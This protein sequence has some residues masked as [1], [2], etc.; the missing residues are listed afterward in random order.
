[1]YCTDVYVRK[2]DVIN[3]G[4]YAHNSR[5]NAII[6][7]QILPTIQQRTQQNL[8]KI[9]LMTIWL[10]SNDCVRSDS[11]FHVSV[12]DFNVNM[13][14]MISLIRDHSPETRIILITPGPCQVGRIEA[15]LYAALN[16]P[17]PP[18]RSNTQVK[19]YV[20]AVLEIGAKTGIPVVNT[21]SAIWAAAG[22]KD[23]STLEPFFTDGLHLAAPGYKVSAARLSSP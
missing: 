8:P 17:N 9:R 10:G 12:P 20:D 21:W 23:D 13:T 14:E 18:V 6:L 11:P 5:W 4:Y 1:M 2:L 22:S 3:R 19:P 16:I 7:K 15:T